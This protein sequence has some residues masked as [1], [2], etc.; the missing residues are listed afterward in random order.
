[1]RNR[2]G[3]MVFSGVASVVLS[4]CG[5]TTT[6][7]NHPAAPATATRGANSSA[8]ST[9][10]GIDVS[11]LWDQTLVTCPGA[12]LGGDE[13]PAD[14]N[15]YGIADVW[16]TNTEVSGILAGLHPAGDSAFTAAR[17]L[18]LRIALESTRDDLTGA[19]DPKFHPAPERGFTQAD[20]DGQQR[21]YIGRIHSGWTTAAE[22]LTAEINAGRDLPEDAATEHVMTQVRGIEVARCQ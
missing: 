16:P 21:R 11:A 3:V 7:L 12:R 22:H 18:D 10:P 9:T 13:P 20:A 1:M 17:M 6:V 14:A 8:Y 2:V 19:R 15:G 5:H 4:A